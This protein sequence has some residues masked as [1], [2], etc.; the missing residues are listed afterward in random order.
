MPFVNERIMPADVEKYR[1][2]EIDKRFIVGGTHAR[3]WTID[4]DR[5]IYL[6]EVATGREEFASDSTWTLLWRGELIQVELTNISLSGPV[7]GVRHG[8]KR[9]TLLGIP[10]HLRV[11]RDEI[12]ADLREAL[13]AYKD[14]GV[15]A[16]ATS[17][18]LTLDV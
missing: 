1:L 10:P 12:I 11:H 8:H 14:G 2:G 6:R 7:G 17:Y 18:T 4:R 15:Y 16:S 13:T 3:D 5:D 9:V